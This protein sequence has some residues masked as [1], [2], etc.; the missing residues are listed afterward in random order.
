LVFKLLKE[1]G[2]RAS[3]RNISELAKKRYP[4]L[5]LH[6][7]VHTRLNA[8]AK[9]GYV[10]RNPDRTWQIVGEYPEP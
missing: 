10:K 9:W 7:Y 1:L 6:K 8:L 2:G 5:S 4:D 3:S